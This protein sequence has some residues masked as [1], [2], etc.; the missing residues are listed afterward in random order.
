LI[1]CAA[2]ELA[3]NNDSLW[4]LEGIRGSG[5]QGIVS[6]EFFVVVY[7]NYVC[8]LEL[9][10][11]ACQ[12]QPGIL[13]EYTLFDEVDIIQVCQT[14][15]ME[16]ATDQVTAVLRVLAAVRKKFSAERFMGVSV[17]ADLPTC[18]KLRD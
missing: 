15:A 9:L 17:K 12:F 14:I 10:H 13:M 11:C 5:V 18:N 2:A 4:S 1:S 3:A 16:V 7:M 6:M 8:L